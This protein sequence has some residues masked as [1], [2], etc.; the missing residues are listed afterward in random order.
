MIHVITQASDFTKVLNA[1]CRAR[2][3]H[4]ALHHL[5]RAA[6]LDSGYRKPDAPATPPSVQTEL[7]TA[8]SDSKAQ[9]VDESALTGYWLGLVVPKRHAK[10][11][12]TRTLLKRRIRAAVSDARGLAPGMWVVR[13]R[14]PFARTEFISAASDRLSAA[15]TDE[16]TRL[17]SA[18]VSRAQR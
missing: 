10:R 18:A 12:V 6:G 8:P 2:S 7:S 16:L 1:P 15:V 17:M 13:L 14:T 4:F 9:A 5:A 11:A 3:Q